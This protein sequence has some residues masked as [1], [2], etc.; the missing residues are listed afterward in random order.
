[1]V[2]SSRSPHRHRHPLTNHFT[3]LLIVVILA[4]TGCADNPKVQAKITKPQLGSRYVTYSF[5]LPNAQKIQSDN[6]KEA[7]A[8][9]GIS[10]VATSEMPGCP[11]EDL[12]ATYTPDM[13]ELAIDLRPG[14]EY[15]I[16]IDGVGT[17]SKPTTGTSPGTS[18]STKP[19]SEKPSEDKPSDDKP[20]QNSTSLAPT[21]AKDIEPLMSKHCVSCH[22]EQGPMQA[23][24]IATYGQVKTRIAGIIE[25]IELQNMP[26]KGPYFSENQIKKLKDWRDQG[27][28]QGALNLQNTSDQTQKLLCTSKVFTFLAKAQNRTHGATP[29]TFTWY[30]EDGF[31]KP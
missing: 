18:P 16:K 29:T 1:M 23:Y 6:P 21:Y 31:R 26:P 7:F 12:L 22:I 14:C 3:V 4:L 11:G 30:F 2:K 27:F 17:I 20:A 9:Q 5:T 25:R 13:K 24:P 19:D 15:S 8:L 10:L 28:A